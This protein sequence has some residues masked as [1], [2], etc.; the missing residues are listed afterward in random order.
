MDTTT[1]TFWNF[2]PPFAF[3]AISW[4]L[5]NCV[6]EKFRKLS[7]S[8]I[9]M[10][11]IISILIFIYYQNLLFLTKELLHYLISI[12]KYLLILL[13]III[14]III[15]YLF[16]RFKVKSEFMN[17]RGLNLE[18][19]YDILSGHRRYKI[20]DDFKSYCENGKQMIL[21]AEK[22][23]KNNKDATMYSVQMNS[24]KMKEPEEEVFQDYI[25]TIYKVVLNNCWRYKRLIYVSPYSNDEFIY[26]FS[27]SFSFIRTLLLECY[28]C[29][30]KTSEYDYL[31]IPNT[32][33]FG[34]GNEV[35][36]NKN[37]KIYEGLKNISIGYT[38][39]ING[40]LDIVSKLDINLPPGDEFSLAFTN[41]NSFAGC[42]RVSTQN[43][44]SNG[45]NNNKNDKNKPENI[46]KYFTMLFDKFFEEYK[47][48]HKGWVIITEI[49]KRIDEV[50]K[51]KIEDMK[52]GI[53]GIFKSWRDSE[54]DKIIF[55]LLFDAAKRALLSTNIYTENKLKELQQSTVDFLKKEKL[56][57]DFNY[58]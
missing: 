40:L 45:L 57:I 31:M 21:R 56:V 8:I 38:A 41:E 35:Y 39:N 16:L 5:S 1:I 36:Q 20:I 17:I 18:N 28:F 50:G 4:F 27:R 54:I 10:G 33:K 44:K 30:E 24:E 3:F 34:V 43:F 53:D 25:A 7:W 9:V 42:I 2:L 13:G 26:S 12:E 37:N 6:K 55:D 51:L 58:S 32:Y 29:K 22:K 49:S 48:S 15:Y 23:F 46:K 19:F 11:G 47:I 14:G 52:E